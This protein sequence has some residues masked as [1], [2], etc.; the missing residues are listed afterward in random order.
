MLWKEVKTWATSIGYKVDR[1]KVKDQCNSYN[2]TWQHE[3][4]S[5]VAYSSF[6][7]AKDIYNHITDNK[8]SNYQINF[9]KHKT[10]DN[11]HSQQTY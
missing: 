6:D 5:G 11:I 10:Y 8:Y 7:V 4:A 9:A 3:A 2:Y 1:T